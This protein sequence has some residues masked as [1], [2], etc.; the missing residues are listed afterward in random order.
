MNLNKKTIS[1]VIDYEINFCALELIMH[2]LLNN[3]YSLN[4]YCSYSL[5]NT[6]SNS[7]TGDRI[8]IVPLDPLRKQTHWAYVMH[9]VLRGL[10][11]N[12]KFS[13]SSWYQYSNM[14]NSS[15]AVKRC[16][17]YTLNK[18]PKLKGNT[19][20]QFLMCL[21]PLF[22][23][24]VFRTQKVLVA[25]RTLV[26]ELLC[27]RGLK[28]FSVIESWD[29]PGKYPVGFTSVNVFAWNRDIGEDWIRYQGGDTFTVS[30]PMKHRYV[31]EHLR[32]HL[33]V[34]VTPLKGAPFILYA[35]ASN[36]QTSNKRLFQEELSF[37]GEICE[38]ALAHQRTVFIKP[39]AQGNTRDF[40]FLLDRYPNVVIG[41]YKD[42]GDRPED[43]YLD[44]DYNALRLKE[45]QQCDLMVNGGTT[46]GIDAALFGLPVLQ[47]DF[48]DANQYPATSQA[49]TNYH[50]KKYF[51][52]D[53]NLTISIRGSTTVFAALNEYLSNPD[54]R[55]ARYGDRLRNWIHTDEPIGEAMDRVFKVIHNS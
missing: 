8:H 39:K 48:C 25:A 9:R 24:S 10:V 6:V 30:Y 44:A 17:Y 28:V 37:I 36:G 43:Y 21:M 34:S 14:C 46:F 27:A 4:V 19:V 23:R 50:L 20:N 26:P 7:F 5:I 38:A 12:P 1:V 51:V 29:H 35:F 55:E 54:G 40:D 3:G 2:K 13:C 18:L 33:P 52:S 16:L 11:T 42:S 45:L 32:D 47:L 31:I 15:S 53:P 22:I 41:S 49:F